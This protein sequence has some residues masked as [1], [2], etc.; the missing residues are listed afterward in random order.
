MLVC[1]AL[2]QRVCLFSIVMC[3]FL[4]ALTNSRGIRFDMF[5]RGNLLRLVQGT[6]MFRIT[7]FRRFSLDFRISV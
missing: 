5:V 4:S 7:D 3:C 1:L 2:Q 6:V